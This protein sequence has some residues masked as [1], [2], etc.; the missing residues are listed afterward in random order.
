MP[1][2]YLGVTEAAEMLGITKGGLTSQRLPAPDAIVGKA[3]GWKRETLLAWAASRPGKGFG[4]GRPRKVK[5][6]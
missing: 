6:V 2:I 5:S 3:R 4:G 1:E